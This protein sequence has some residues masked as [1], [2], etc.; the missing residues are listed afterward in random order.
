[1]SRLF[2]QTNFVLT[3]KTLRFTEQHKHRKTAR[4]NHASVMKTVCELFIP[5]HVTDVTTQN[6]SHSSSS[7]VSNSQFVSLFYK[8]IPTTTACSS[9]SSSSS[10]GISSTFSGNPPSGGPKLTLWLY[11][12]GS[13]Y[14]TLTPTLTIV[15]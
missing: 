13:R 1:M 7:Y 2:F 15:T 3:T 9:S 14:I 8:S 11:N 10:N 12:K 4:N 5:R 6:N